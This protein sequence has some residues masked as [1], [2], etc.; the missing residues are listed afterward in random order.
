MFT[1]LTDTMEIIKNRVRNEYLRI[2]VG[3]I[4]DEKSRQISNLII[5]SVLRYSDDV[6]NSDLHT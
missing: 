6:N 5:I 3:E 2:F 1:N 4:A